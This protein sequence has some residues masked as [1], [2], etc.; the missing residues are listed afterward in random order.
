MG[1]LGMLLASVEPVQAVHRHESDQ[2]E[3]PDLAD[4]IAG[5]ASGVRAGGVAACDRQ[6]VFGVATCD[7]ADMSGR[8]ADLPGA[9]GVLGLVMAQTGLEEQVGSKLLGA[10]AYCSHE[11]PWGNIDVA[12]P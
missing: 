8:A 6:K 4:E 5:G 10:H 2:H 9:Q 12:H 7:I 3:S 11:H 1:G